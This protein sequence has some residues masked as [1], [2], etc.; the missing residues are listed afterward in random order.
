MRTHEEAAIKG[1]GL[2]QFLGLI[3]RAYIHNIHLAFN[4]SVKRARF[5]DCYF[6]FCESPEKEELTDIFEEE[7]RSELLIHRGNVNVKNP[8]SKTVLFNHE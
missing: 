8:D 1:G 6:R 5:W 3:F 2:A 4:P 7:G